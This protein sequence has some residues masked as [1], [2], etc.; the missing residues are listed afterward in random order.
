MG[1]LWC[2]QAG[3]RRARRALRS[4]CEKYRIRVLTSRAFIGFTDHLHIR[5]AMKKA[6]AEVVVH[7]IAERNE[8]IMAFMIEAWKHRAAHGSLSRRGADTLG[9]WVRSS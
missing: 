4:M 2:Q 1:S 6:V 3:K 9:Q 5:L 7:W 8:E